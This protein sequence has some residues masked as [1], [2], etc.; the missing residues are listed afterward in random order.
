MVQPIRF[1]DFQKNTAEFLLMIIS[2]D[3]T[4]LSTYHI[5]TLGA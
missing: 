4:V 5:P 3:I 2:L 1:A